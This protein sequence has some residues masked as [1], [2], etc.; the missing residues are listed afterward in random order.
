MRKKNK[1]QN[2]GDRSQKTEFAESKKQN[3]KSELIN[4]E[5]RE[6][7]GKTCS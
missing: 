1:R 3:S 5:T 7:G 4:L 6:A 2:S